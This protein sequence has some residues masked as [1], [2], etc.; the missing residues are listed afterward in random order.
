MDKLDSMGQ[1]KSCYF[2][3][4]VPGNG[5]AADYHGY[6]PKA[7]INCISKGVSV[8]RLTIVV[9]M[10]SLL[11]AITTWLTPFMKSF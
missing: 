2:S 10:L 3:I 5:V 7:M 6:I 9:A 4:Q 11:V 1:E 8:D